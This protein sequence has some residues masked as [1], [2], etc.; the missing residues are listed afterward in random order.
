MIMRIVIS[1]SS[2][3]FDRCRRRPDLRFRRIMVCS[4]VFCCGSRPQTDSGRLSE[5]PIVAA[6]SR[7]AAVHGQPCSRAHFSTSS[8]P[9]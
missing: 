4:W 5:Y 7:V 9:P 6:R 3:S 2:S 8:C 1:H